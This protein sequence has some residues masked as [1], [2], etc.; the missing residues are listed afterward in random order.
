MT[1]F[2]ISAVCLFLRVRRKRGW[3][4][5]HHPAVSKLVAQPR[6]IQLPLIISCCRSWLPSCP[7][8]EWHLPADV[9]PC[10]SPPLAWLLLSI[11]SNSS[12]LSCCFYPTV[13]T[14]ELS[15]TRASTPDCFCT[16]R[17]ESACRHPQPG[18]SI[19]CLA[20][21]IQAGVPDL[22]SSLW[23][24]PVIP[25]SCSYPRVGAPGWEP[26]PQPPIR[27]LALSLP[28]HSFL[29]AIKS[30][31]FILQALLRLVFSSRPW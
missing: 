31:R 5:L 12:E 21:D 20:S 26:Y 9:W 11:S 18:C 19:P 24:D 6:V 15:S 22:G 1:S 30:L 3:G 29:S 16:F 14:H 27:P 7:P 17:S 2:I 10:M 23:W 25:V 4:C 13:C 28:R 8:P